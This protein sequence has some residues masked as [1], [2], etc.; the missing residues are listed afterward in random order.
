MERAS[1]RPSESSTGALGHPYLSELARSESRSESGGINTNMNEKIAIIGL[2]YVGLPVALSLGDASDD[3]IGFDI[4][5]AKVRQLKE[6]FDRT[7]EVDPDELKSTR[8]K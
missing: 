8:V 1:V 5:A 7:S 2:G 3:V 6:G 4:D